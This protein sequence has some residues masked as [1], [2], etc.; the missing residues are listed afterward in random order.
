MVITIYNGLC[1]L[2]FFFLATCTSPE[3]ALPE[4]KQTHLAKAGTTIL[5]D[6]LSGKPKMEKIEI[7][8]SIT[9][10]YLT[11]KFDPA[12]HPDFTTIDAQ[13]ASRTGMY[14]RKDA[15]AAFIQMYEAAKKENIHFQI[16]SATRNFDRQKTI[17][18]GKW[19]GKRLLEG[20]QSAPQ[21]Y[22]APQDRALKILEYSSMPGTSRH[23]WGTDIDLNA[24][25][26]AYFEKGQGLKEYQWL[27][28]HAAHYGFCQPYTQK[29]PNRP[30]GYNE[31]KWHWSYMPM[32]IRLTQQYPLQVNY[33][34]F[35]RFRFKGSGTASG[36]DVIQNYVLGIDPMCMKK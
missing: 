15:Y 4:N 23:H 19:S 14:L 33:S 10:A 21:D 16:K 2:A 24:F 22:P 29:G 3:A 18:E 30:N 26:N 28:A 35:E 36:I 13:H 8:T 5:K 9:A 17:W 34:D 12:R 11:G 27:L 7:D 1:L 20:G 6:T 32:A 25:N 31:E